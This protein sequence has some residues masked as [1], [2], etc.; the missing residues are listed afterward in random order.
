MNKEFFQVVILGSTGS[1]GRQALEVAETFQEHCQV[2]GLA[3]GSNL[4]L[5]EEQVKK[6]HPQKVAI[7]NEKLKEQIKNYPGFRDTEIVWGMAGLCH[8]AVLPKADLIIQALG[9]AVGILPTAASIRAGKRIG[10]A[11]KETLVA[12]GDI[13]MPLAEECRADI[14]PVD[15]EHSAIFQCMQGEKNPLKALWLTASGGPFYK[16]NEEDLEKVCVEDALHHPR[17]D[18]GAKITIDSATMMNKGL[19]VIE[20]HHLFQMPYEDIKVLVHPESAVHSMIETADHALIAQM[21]AADMRLPIQYAFTWPERRKSLAQ[22]LDL[23]DFG[24]LH[25]EKPDIQKFPALKMA[26]E[27]GKTGGTLPAAMNAANETAVAAFLKKRIGFRDIYR[28]TQAVADQHDVISHPD[29]E[30]I[31]TADKETRIKTENYLKYELKK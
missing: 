22:R 30:D 4:A 15:S 16:L 21:G 26:Y 9:G 2:I 3:G 29:L 8:L 20:A 6:W 7:G 25:F 10:L 17:W 23:S 13:I 27:A 11:N 31:L 28:V 24:T 1:I 5:L 12:A 14:I 18:M 19:E